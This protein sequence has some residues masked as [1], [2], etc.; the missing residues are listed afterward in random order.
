MHARY[1]LFNLFSPNLQSENK[2][3]LFR[4]DHYMLQDNIQ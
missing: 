2:T 4:K 1:S 3:N